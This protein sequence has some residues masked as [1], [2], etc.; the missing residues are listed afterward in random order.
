MSL[1]QISD[2]GSLLFMA[3]ALGLDGFSVSLSIGLHQIRLKRVALIGL[4]IGLFHF[5]LPFIGMIIGNFISLKLE[6]ITSFIA[7]M[8]LVLIGSYMVFSA[9]Q[10]KSKL[11]FNPYS[12]QMLSIALLV[13]IDS[14]P[15]G[16]SIGLSGIQSVMVIFFIGF[17]AM[18]FSWTGMLIGKKTNKLFGMYSEILGGVILFMVGLNGLF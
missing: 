18:I 9:L 12:I 3:I 2:F 7:S 16:L 13:S 8:I 4:I 10:K 6:H 17:I 15:V 11:S 1:E 5:L 14:F